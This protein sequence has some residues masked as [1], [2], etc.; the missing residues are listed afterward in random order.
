MLK[1]FATASAVVAL[2][3]A[4][5]AVAQNAAAPASPT[6]SSDQA[7]P[8]KLQ[9]AQPATAQPSTDNQ[10]A[11]PAAKPNTNEA[12][13]PAAKPNTQVAGTADKFLTQQQDGQMLASNIMGQ[14]VYDSGGNNLGSVNDI[15]FDKDNHIVAVVIGVGGFLGIGQKNVAVSMGAISQTTDENGKPKLVL[16]ATK[17]ALDQ[18][19]AFET[20]ADLNAKKQQQ[21]QQPAGGAG[22]AGGA[23]GAGGAMAPANPNPANPATTTQ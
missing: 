5:P 21:M 6:T 3:A 13:A 1:A 14:T 19:P 8:K 7:Q 15:V 16:D 20:L 12:A 22:G 17:D 11:A 9:P 4:A 2:L 10:A 23:T 18:A